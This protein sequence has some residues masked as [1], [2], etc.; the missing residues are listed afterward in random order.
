MTEANNGKTICLEVSDTVSL[1]LDGNPTTGYMWEISSIDRDFLQ[2]VEQSYNSS[3]DLIGAGG[4]FTFTFR[5][6]AKGSTNLCLVYARPWEKTSPPAKTFEVT[7][8]ID[9]PN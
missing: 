6:A 4:M 9:S 8:V 1:N 7:V 3:S 5:A 2:V